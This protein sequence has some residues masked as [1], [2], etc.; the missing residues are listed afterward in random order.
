[1][2]Y[3]STVS[4]IISPFFYWK[5]GT[6]KNDLAPNAWLHRALLKVTGMNP[7]EALNHSEDPVISNN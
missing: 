6:H 3:Y 5:K 7:V 2:T 4:L 1:M